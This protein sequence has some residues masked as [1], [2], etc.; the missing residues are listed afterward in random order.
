MEKTARIRG[1]GGGGGGGLKT[2]K[3]CEELPVSPALYS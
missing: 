2:K 3:K 1:G